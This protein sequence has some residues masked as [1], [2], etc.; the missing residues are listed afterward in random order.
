MRSRVNWDL[1]IKINR[2]LNIYLSL[3]GDE[4]VILSL[5]E[6]QE[7]Q[8]TF[9]EYMFYHLIYFMIYQLF[10]SSKSTIWTGELHF[11][12]WIFHNFSIFIIVVLP[13]SQPRIPAQT[14]V[15]F[16]K[17]PIQVSLVHPSF[18]ISLKGLFN[19]YLARGNSLLDQPL[20]RNSRRLEDMTIVGIT[21]PFLIVF[22][23][24]E[25]NLLTC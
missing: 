19:N 20:H 2:Y 21:L 1:H 22:D 15:G 6:L 12:D 7:I 11:S 25:I 16:S 24:I 8:K 9:H 3:I 4:P 13:V 10:L 23:V 14:V 18:H 5:W 17:C